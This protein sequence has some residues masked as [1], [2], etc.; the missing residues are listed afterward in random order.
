MPVFQVF[1]KRTNA[2]IKYKKYGK[3]TKILDVKQK[4]PSKPFKGIKK[5]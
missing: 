3:K 2:W 4:N 5:K 1:N